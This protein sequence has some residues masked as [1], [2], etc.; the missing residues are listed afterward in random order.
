MRGEGPGKMKTLIGHV[1][2]RTRDN[3]KKF[4]F[5]HTGDFPGLTLITC[6]RAPVRAVVPYRILYLYVDQGHNLLVIFFHVAVRQHAVQCMT[7][8]VVG[9]QAPQTAGVA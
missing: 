6:C 8:S 3:V 5:L 7:H 4:L 2:R 1:A 9:A